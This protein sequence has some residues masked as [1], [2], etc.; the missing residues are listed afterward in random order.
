M[1]SL[2]SVLQLVSVFGLYQVNSRMWEIKTEDGEIERPLFPNA[3]T[4]TKPMNK[5]ELKENK[6]TKIPN[7][8]F[9]L[10]SV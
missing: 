9:L 7:I 5:K 2:E 8:L 3:K 6:Q 1:Y 4:Q 10:V